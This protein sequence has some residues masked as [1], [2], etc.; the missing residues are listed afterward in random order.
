MNALAQ[1]SRKRLHSPFAEFAQ[2]QEALINRVRFDSLNHREQRIVMN[3][4]FAN[5]EDIKHITHALTLLKPEGRLVA[6]CAN[7]PRQ[8]NALR[9]LVTDLK[10]SS[11]DLPADTFKDAG[12]GVRT[13]L[14]TIDKPASEHVPGTD[15][16]ALWT[17]QGVPAQQQLNMPDM[18]DATAAPGAKVGP[19][20]L[21]D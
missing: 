10:G 8:N 7:G 14:L 4:P 2:V 11:E 6:I 18:I 9:P 15:L 21:R 17:A 19:F 13:V 12:T 16:R 20:R 5:A 3:P 1:F